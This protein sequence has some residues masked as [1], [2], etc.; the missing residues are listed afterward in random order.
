[1]INFIP[2]KDS[3]IRIKIKGGFHHARITSIRMLASE[4]MYAICK[5]E[6]TFKD[7]VLCPPKRKEATVL[8][9]PEVLK[10]LELQHNQKGK[11]YG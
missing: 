1:M 9:S 2:K 11:R 8:L 7:G 5:I 10:E 4:D 6:R 3:K